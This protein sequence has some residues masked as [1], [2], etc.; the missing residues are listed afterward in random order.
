M[1]LTKDTIAKLAELYADDTEMLETLGDILKSF[2]NY[3]AAIYEMET[4]M[5]IM[6]KN[7]YD[8]KDYQT[9]IE[10]LDSSRTNSHNAVIANVSMLNRL[11]ELSGQP[12]VYEGIVSKERPYRRE[13]A[14]A[15]LELAQ[16]II[17]ARL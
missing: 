12:P 8:T 10:N 16:E 14:N 15:V 2:E 6:N 9:M 3:H 11:A 5:L 1:A 4:K 13:I 7:A 17:L